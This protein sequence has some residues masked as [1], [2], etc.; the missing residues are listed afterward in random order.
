MPFVAEVA[1]LKAAFVDIGQ[2]KNAFLHYWDIL[3]AAS[4]NTIEVVRDN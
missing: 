1:R 4:D 2:P 3:P